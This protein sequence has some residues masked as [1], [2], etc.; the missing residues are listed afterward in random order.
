MCF[1]LRSWRAG[2]SISL[3]LI[4]QIGDDFVKNISLIFVATFETMHKKRRLKKPL[5]GVMDIWMNMVHKQHCPLH[6]VHVGRCQ[7]ETPL[8][9]ECC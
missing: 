5:T 2:F 7:H 6:A 1:F 4:K 8:P 3:M 9:A